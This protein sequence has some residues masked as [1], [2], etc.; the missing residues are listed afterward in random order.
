[1][2]LNSQLQLSRLQKAKQNR[3]NPLPGI[4]NPTQITRKLDAFEIG[5]LK[6]AVN[7]WD[8]LEQRDD[9]IRTVVSK[10]KKSIGRQGWTV[11]IRDSVTPAQR[12]EAEQHAAAL[13]YFYQ[14][15][16]CENALDR[17][18][19]GGFKLLCRQMMDAIGKRFA[20][21][22]IV[23]KVG[24]AGSPSLPS[25]N[26]FSLRNAPDL[27]CQMKNAHLDSRSGRQDLG[28]KIE[29]GL[30][31]PCSRLNEKT[32]SSNHYLTASRRALSPLLA[33]LHTTSLT[34]SIAS[35]IAFN[36][37]SS[38]QRPLRNR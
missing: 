32:S 13:E 4:T 31:T 9:L 22:E 21:H 25:F 27:K 17:A 5:Y 37:C 28:T 7:I 23:W 38:C 15:L 14:N 8:S 16:R 29:A 18:E 2:N 19:R 35:R 30:G 3:Y 11:Q 36:R 33:N 26:N 12:A 34:Q 20:V 10:R 1:M 24:G 6:D